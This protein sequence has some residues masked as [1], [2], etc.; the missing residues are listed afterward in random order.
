MS[1]YTMRVNRRYLINWF[2]FAC[3]SNLD[4]CKEFVR[5]Q[6]VIDFTFE[7]NLQNASK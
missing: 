7:L 2:L 5:K 3:G 6:E 1:K 4:L